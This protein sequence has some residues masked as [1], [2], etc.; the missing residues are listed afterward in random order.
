MKGLRV[1][2]TKRDQ[3]PGNSRELWAGQ[4]WSRTVLWRAFRAKVTG[5]RF[6]RD[7]G[8]LTIAKCAGASLSFLQGIV[9]ARWLGPELYGTAALV[10]VPPSLVY[11][12]FDARSAEVIVKYLSEFHARGERTRALAMCQLGYMADLA[13]ASVMFLTVLTTAPWVARSVVRH[14]E[15]AGL[16][17]IYAAAY[18][19]HA[20]AGTAYATLAV[21]GR[22]PVIAWVDTFLTVLRVALVLGLVLRGWQVAGVVW[23]NAVA[24]TATGLLYGTIAGVLMRRT[25]GAPPPQGSWHALKGYRR[26]IFGFLA[27]NDLNALI[28]MIPKQL[29]VV[30]LGYFQSPTEV[31]Y[32][33]LAKRISGVMDYLVRPLQ[34]VAYPELARLWGLGSRQAL[35]R[36]V[37]RLAVLLGLPLGLAA[38]V[39]TPLITSWLPV[40]VGHAYRPAATAVQLLLPGS[41]VYLAF[42]WLRPLFLARAWIKEWTN[43]T[44]LFALCNLAGWLIIVPRHGYVGMS[45][46]WL[47]S[48]TAVYILPRIIFLMR[49]GY[50]GQK[51]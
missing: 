28:A 7:V 12:F 39:A 15:A 5:G 50:D 11:A 22:F 17:V 48:M 42:F 38:V 45:A 4:P 47:F 24:M 21:L 31:G 1:T 18:V 20:L 10:M 14:P 46:W 35:R 32:Y 49:T 23:G 8:V 33:K 13:I 37:W 44:V 40:I 6:V 34:S 51:S 3:D 25:W 19:P 43:F 26:E 30:L 41:A 16:M 36:K 9:V 29:D 2:L 27:Y